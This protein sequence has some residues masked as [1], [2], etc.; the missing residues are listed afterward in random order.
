MSFCLDLPYVRVIHWL[1]E[2]KCSLNLKPNYLVIFWEYITYEPCRDKYI[3]MQISSNFFIVALPS[4][5][6][7]LSNVTATSKF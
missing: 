5:V 3:V 7:L 6:V 2:S 1:G 4:V